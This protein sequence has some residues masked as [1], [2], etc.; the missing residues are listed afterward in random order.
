MINILSRT[1]KTRNLIRRSFSTGHS[2]QTKKI[3]Y[4]SLVYSQLTYCS[5]IW[6]PHLLKDIITLEINDYVSSAHPPVQPHSNIPKT[7]SS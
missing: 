4:L 1:Y 3:L 7:M 5:Q 2:P 6:R